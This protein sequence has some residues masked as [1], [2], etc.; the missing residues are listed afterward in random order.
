V[1]AIAESRAT[2]GFVAIADVADG[3]ISAVQDPIDR[4]NGLLM[5]AS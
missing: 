2:G 5:K 4:A 3:T 1:W